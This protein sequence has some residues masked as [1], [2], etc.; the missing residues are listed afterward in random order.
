MLSL[1]VSGQR[2][3]RVRGGSFER[4]CVDILV[5]TIEELARRESVHMMKW[6]ISAH[7]VGLAAYLGHSLVI[8]NS[9]CT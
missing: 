4:R 8:I 2:W 7:G 6:Y 5:R 3:P 1:L 9:N